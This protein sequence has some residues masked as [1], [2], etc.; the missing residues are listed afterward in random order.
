MKKILLLVMLAV[1]FIA[2]STSS[3]AEQKRSI[4]CQIGYDKEE[5]GNR[6]GYSKDKEFMHH[7]I[8]NMMSKKMVA[9][10][11]GGVIVLVGNKLLKYDKDLNL[12]KESEIKIDMEAYKAKIKECYLEQD[13]E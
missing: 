5:K 6:T 7:M 9:S 3:Y 12:I 13:S 10:G 2:S 4:E 8:K 11:D 1:F